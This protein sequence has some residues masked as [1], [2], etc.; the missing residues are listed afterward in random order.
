M[1]SDRKSDPDLRTLH[2]RY[3]IEQIPFCCDNFLLPAT[4][5][6]IGYILEIIM[7]FI[8]SKP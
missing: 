6:F 7:E 3:R 1:S 4:Y 5:D 2:L 8:N